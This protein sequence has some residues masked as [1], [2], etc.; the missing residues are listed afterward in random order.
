MKP[1]KFTILLLLITSMVGCQTLTQQGFLTSTPSQP[2][3]SSNLTDQSVRMS[4]GDSHPPSNGLSTEHPNQTAVIERNQPSMEF[5]EIRKMIQSGHLTV[6][7][8][9]LKNMA[10]RHG[11]SA[12][13]LHHLAIIYAKQGSTRLAK[14]H[15]KRALA[16]NSDDANLQS[17]FGYFCFDSGDFKQAETCFRK[18]ISLDPSLQRPHNNLGL[19]LTMTNRQTQAFHHFQQAGLDPQQAKFNMMSVANSPQHKTAKLR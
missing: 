13:I 4:F 16:Y 8:G 11:E 10:K 5:V 2:I 15:F 6:A 12:S 1:I 7:A 3:Q 18:A 14:K 17:D 9:K 19:L